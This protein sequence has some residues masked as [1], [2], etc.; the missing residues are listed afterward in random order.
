MRGNVNVDIYIN[1]VREFLKKN[2]DA[3][4]Y[5]FGNKGEE[6]FYELLTIFAIENFE[7]NDDPSLSIEQFEEIRY[8]VIAKFGTASVSDIVYTLPFSLN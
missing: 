8:A 2:E 3:A 4:E 6:I 5:F 7:Q 1:N